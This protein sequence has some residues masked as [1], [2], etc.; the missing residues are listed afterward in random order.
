VRKR[1]EKDN[2]SK[3]GKRRIIAI[4]RKKKQGPTSR[5]QTA[6]RKR[7]SGPEESDHNPRTET[8]AER[9][10]DGIRVMPYGP[11]KRGLGRRKKKH[12]ETSQ[13]KSIRP[14]KGGTTLS[15]EGSAGKKRH[16][17]PERN[18]GKEKSHSGG[19]CGP[20]PNKKKGKPGKK[21]LS[22][23][24]KEKRAGTVARE[25]GEKPPGLIR[26]VSGHGSEARDGKRKT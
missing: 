6:G 14:R 4:T 24:M 21:G 15:R 10:R 16:K 20:F 8:A 26:N 1:G 13:R 18:T 9:E 2:F 5:T 22:Q 19:M 3:T 7:T 23:N 12:G 17:R 11:R 25:K